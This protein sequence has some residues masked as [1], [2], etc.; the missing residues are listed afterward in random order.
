MT[1]LL[2]TKKESKKTQPKY[3]TITIEVDEGKSSLDLLK[4][5]DEKIVNLDMLIAR[6][7]SENKPHAGMEALKN[8]L[9][10]LK[11]QILEQF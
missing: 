6:A 5:V 2:L 1:T 8:E 3:N 11:Y 7:I 4:E 9:W 10:Y